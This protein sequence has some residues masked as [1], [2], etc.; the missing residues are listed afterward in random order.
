[1][2]TDMEGQ[3]IATMENLKKSLDAVGAT[4]ANV[5]VANRFLTD[6]S[7]QD[8]L[9]KMWNKY[10][11]DNKPTTTT[12]QVVKLATDP[13][14]LVEI[15]AI[16]GL[17]CLSLKANDFKDLNDRCEMSKDPSSEGLGV[18]Q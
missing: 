18:L 12:V 13:R 8:V 2:P 7:Q 9:N 5:V 10:V 1:M 17:T 16:A 6:L 3:A 14:C 4:F 11:G 15:N